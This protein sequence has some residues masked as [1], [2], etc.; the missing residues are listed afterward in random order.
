MTLDLEVKKIK[1]HFFA[2]FTSRKGRFF[3]VHTG[4]VWYIESK[5]GGGEHEDSVY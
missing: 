4:N 2:Y 3:I 1:G 5:E